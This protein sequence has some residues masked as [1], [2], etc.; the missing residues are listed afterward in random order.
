MLSYIIK[1]T[2]P[3]INIG[4][5]ANWEL[6]FFFSIT[7]HLFV[8][9]VCSS[10]PLSNCLMVILLRVEIMQQKLRFTFEAWQVP[11]KYCESALVKK[12]MSQPRYWPSLFLTPNVGRENTH[13]RYLFIP[14]MELN[15]KT[16]YLFL[17]RDN[18][19]LNFN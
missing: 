3:V 4:L 8:L 17:V 5:K 12:T 7:L 2:K 9:L 6:F 11:C 10:F 15:K 19:L 14:W 13:A 1:R 16:T 18:T